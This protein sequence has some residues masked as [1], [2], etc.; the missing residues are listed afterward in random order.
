MLR[1]AQIAGHGRIIATRSA[2]LSTRRQFTQ[3]PSIPVL[4]PNGVDPKAEKLK[5]DAVPPVMPP[6]PP[7]MP[8]TANA[9]PGDKVVPP[10]TPTEK[11]TTPKAVPFGTEPVQINTDPVVLP[12]KTNRLRNLL[13]FLI[14]G[15]ATLFGGGVYGSL[16]NDTIYEIFTESVPFGE[17]AVLYLQEREFKNRF[18]EA[19]RH[20]SRSSRRSTATNVYI[21]SS[22]VQ[23]RI[24][25]DES[26]TAAA[27]D[28]KPEILAPGPQNSAKLDAHK[29]STASPMQAGATNKVEP[30][31]GPASQS[32]A[33]NTPPS[34]ASRSAAVPAEPAPSKQTIATQPAVQATTPATDAAARKDTASAA[35]AVKA[36]KTGAVEVMSPVQ[37]AKVDRFDLPDIRDRSIDRLVFAI[38]GI[39]QTANEY[40]S[41]PHFRACL[42]NAKDEVR[43]LNAAIATVQGE[44]EQKERVRFDS[45]AKAL[46][47]RLDS[48]LADVTRKSSE[49]E[50]RLSEEL[51][52]ERQRLDQVYQQRLSTE[53]ARIEAVAQ[54]RLMNDLTEQAI[55]LQRLMQ[56]D[57]RNQVEQER[58]GRLGRLE[59]LQKSVQE[60]KQLELDSTEYVQSRAR[61]QDLEVALA[62]LKAVLEESTAR[63]FVDEL[64]AIREI[65]GPEDELVRAAVSSIGRESFERGVPTLGQLADRFRSV[66][67]KVYS[68]SLVPD[69]AGAGG[70]FLS[71][72][73]S[74]AMFQKRGMVEGADVAATLARAEAYLEANDLDS[75]LRE[76][77]TLKGW[78][79]VLIRDW[80]NLARRH[81]EVRQAVDVLQTSAV[82]EALKLRKQEE[83]SV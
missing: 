64:A 3:P 23:A 71:S 35:P 7:T 15:G 44:A 56:R 43:A 27:G 14:F 24:R 20:I 61:V 45:E 46:Q 2:L 75:A 41:S 83:R 73:L 16:K 70:H 40:G 33:A 67:D 49:H 25:P 63:P 31:G 36:D 47:A 81:L 13:L 32:V 66:R 74:T 10:L 38:N 37:T 50:A 48:Q 6:M 79:K 12:K 72:L 29:A 78:P 52:R 59:Q 80:L 11:S 58:G 68:A 76:C 53:V 8:S 1:A 42:D 39:V 30:K 82:L 28:A 21:P 22:G 19:H 26:S 18:P 4:P 55:Q 9:T 60:L 54:K 65:A 57:V 69:D 34:Q 5:R 62:A 17:E 77:N 51:D